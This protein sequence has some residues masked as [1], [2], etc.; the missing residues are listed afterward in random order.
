[1][2]TNKDFFSK[3]YRGE[4]G[5]HPLL[6]YRALSQ[7]LEAYI[8][9]LDPIDKINFQACLHPFIQK[10][11]KFAKEEETN[12]QEKQDLILIESDSLYTINPNLQKKME[13]K[14]NDSLASAVDTGNVIPMM[15]GDVGV[16]DWPS[17]E[18]TD[19]DKIPFALFAPIEND[20]F[21]NKEK[22]N[23]EPP[24]I[25]FLEDEPNKEEVVESMMH[26][27]MASSERMFENITGASTVDENQKKNA[28]NTERPPE[29]TNEIE[30]S[31]VELDDLASSFMVGKM[32]S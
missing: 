19:E 5:C 22:S 23:D 2:L 6:A 13:D 4:G 14:K 28:E 15:I 25:D 24:L 1:M 30:Q 3:Y 32:K 17:E 26:A 7:A 16:N 10:A 27:I 11:L 12:M 21:E 8:E 31:N 20:T 29:R 18:S 9:E